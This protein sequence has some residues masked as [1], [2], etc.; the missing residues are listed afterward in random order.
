MLA[1]VAAAARAGRV[2]AD[3]ASRRARQAAE[4]AARSCASICRR[5]ARHGRAR[6]RGRPC[7]HRGAGRAARSPRSAPSSCAAPTPAACSSQGCRRSRASRSRRRRPPRGLARVSARRRAG[8]TPSQ[9]RRCRA[10]ALGC[11]ATLDAVSR[12]GAAAVVDRGH[13]LAVEC[14]E[15]VAA[16]HR[17]RRRLAPVG[18]PALGAALRRRRARAAPPICDPASSMPPRLRALRAGV[19]VG[20]PPP[21]RARGDAERRS[22][23]P[24]SWRSRAAAEAHHEPSATDARARGR[25]GRSGERSV[26][27]PAATTCACSSSP[28]S[29]RATRSARKLMAALNAQ[30]QGP[31]P[32]SRRRR[33]GH[34]AR[35]ARLAVPARA[36]S[37]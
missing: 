20:R 6:D 12:S 22:P 1:R 7:R 27:A 19:V 28:A 23:R 18:T 13:V 5:S 37:P 31:H 2:G 34:G 25:H 17:A 15:G 8:S 21:T 35:R 30:L 32:L 10:K 36:T 33:R 4:A 29:I 11:C 24:A 9:H 16:L 14:G 26:P 3:A